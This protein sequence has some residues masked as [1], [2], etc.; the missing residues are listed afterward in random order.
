MR[1][2]LQH[3]LQILPNAG[4]QADIFVVPVLN[5]AMAK[6]GIVTRLRIAA[7]LLKSGMNRVN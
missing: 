5:A 4:R 2:T 3:L 1:I 6:Y 7:L